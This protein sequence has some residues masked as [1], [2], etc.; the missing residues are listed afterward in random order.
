MC[1]IFGAYNFDSS[2]IDEN[3]LVAMGL[4][5]EHRG[6]DDQ[7]IYFGKSEA[8]GNQ[9]LSIIDIDGGNQPFSSLDGH[10][11]VVQNGEIYNYLELKKSL[12]K[13]G[14]TFETKSDTEVILK[15]YERDGE[16]FA[17]KLNGMFAIAIFDK[18]LDKLFL[19]RDRVGV[20]PLFFYK[21]DKKFL[22]GSEIKSILK[23]D[24]K[25]EINLDGIN[26]YLTF[27]Y[28]P[29]P[30]TGFKNIYHVKPG[31]YMVISRN[32]K[33]QEKSWWE[34][35]EFHQKNQKEDS[36]IEEF[37][38]ILSEAV[39]IR[40]RSDVEFGAF[41][42]GGVDSS[43]ITG[44]M[45]Q[46]MNEPVET[47]CIGFEDKRF[48]ESIY[49]QKASDLFSTNHNLKILDHN[50]TKDWSKVL[51]SCDQPHGDISF[52][53]TYKLSELAKTKVKMVLTGDGG[54]EIFAGYDKYKSFFSKEKNYKNNDLFKDN[55]YENICLFNSSEK[56]KL[57]ANK[58]IDIKSPKNLFNF[59]LMKVQH[60]DYINQSLYIDMMMLLPG[61]NLVKPDRM[62]MAVSLEARTPFLD[63]RMIELAFSLNGS[64]K[65]KN[66]ET[67]YLMKKALSPLIGKELAY[68]KKQMFTVPIGDWFRSHLYQEVIDYLEKIKKDLF[69]QDFFN[70][71]RIEKLFIDHLDGEENYTRQVRS[72]IALK[73][74]KDI[75]DLS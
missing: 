50:I 56:E 23:G 45:S 70:L 51:Y 29:P 63:Y 53:P 31:S 58:K 17:K 57:I 73:K 61:N 62:G 67:K 2:L 5:I 9:R 28:I 12:I 11:Q 75:F 30:L 40:L 36:F 26:Q 42:S 10:I 44:L 13:E 19:Y 74:W 34:L 72:L 20:K 32:N 52:I 43:S 7:G 16:N 54:D 38:H 27:N 6:P 66:G 46:K 39:S 18:N 14:F 1:G 35:S 3:L 15:L 8:I 60:W 71:E 4:S 55:Y 47:F 64:H 37:N 22:F 33:I 25:K 49:A 65:L 69:F 41:L 24:I 21:D 48:D 68:R 59:H